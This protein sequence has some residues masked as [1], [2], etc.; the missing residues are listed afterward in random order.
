MRLNV[1]GAGGNRTP[2]H[3]AMNDPD[4]TI[5]AVW[6]TQQHRRVGRPSGQI[7][8]AWWPANRLSESSANFLAVSGL[9]HRHPSLLLPGCD[10]LAPCGISAH[11]VSSLT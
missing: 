7:T 8:L 10:G 9:F 6:L 2:V 1:R 11:D 3:Q 4:T 5:P